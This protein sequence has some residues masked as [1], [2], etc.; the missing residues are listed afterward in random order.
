MSFDSTPFAGAFSSV[1]S[2]SFI[3]VISP[4]AAQAALAALPTVLAAVAAA[5]PAT[6]GALTAGV[7]GPGPLSERNNNQA[8]ITAPRIASGTSQREPLAAAESAPDPIAEAARPEAEPIVSAPA[9]S[10]P[11]PGRPGASALSMLPSELAFN[12]PVLCILAR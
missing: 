4:S 3:L 9:L 7:L 10:M 2:G 11:V 6:F 8:R 1:P 5:V 12:E